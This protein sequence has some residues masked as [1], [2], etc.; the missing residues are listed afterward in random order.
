MKKYVE[1]RPWG[2]FEQF[3]HNETCTVK[4][5][6]VNSGAE[7]SLQYH[8]HRDEFWR[9][10][11][12]KAIIV[13]GADEREAKAGDEFFIPRKTNHQIKTTDSSAK[14]MEISFGNFDES[15]IVRLKDIYGRIL[16]T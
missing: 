16:I 2:R 11:E 8:N 15:D 12:G 13:I 3:C 6:S 14:I 10:I 9:I 5:I 4:I 7:L 1:E